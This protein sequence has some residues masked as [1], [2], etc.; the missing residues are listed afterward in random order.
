MC[1]KSTVLILWLC[2][3]AE[4]LLRTPLNNSCSRHL[5]NSYRKETGVI[6]TPHQCR[7]LYATVL[8]DAGLEAKDAQVL[9]EHAQFSTTIDIYTHVKDQRIVKVTKKLNKFTGKTKCV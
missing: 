9:L 5:W 3:K 1:S 7:H 4:A 2:V 6:A 8:S